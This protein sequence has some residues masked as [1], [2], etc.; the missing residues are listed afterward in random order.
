[1]RIHK[2]SCTVNHKSQKEHQVQ[3]V[4]MFECIHPIARGKVRGLPQVRRG[5]DS[6]RSCVHVLTLTCPIARVDRMDPFTGVYCGGLYTYY[7][8]S[9]YSSMEGYHLYYKTGI[10]VYV[11]IFLMMVI[12]IC[13][14][15]V[16]FD[17][18]R[19]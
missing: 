11:S 12:I 13:S 7:H 2:T 5:K 6:I 17:L 9:T 15:T 18:H 4:R 10:C 16:I 3:A 19:I 1:M 8:T 14:Y